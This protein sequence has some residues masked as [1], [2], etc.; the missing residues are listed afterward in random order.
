[1]VERSGRRLLIVDDEAG[2]VDLLKRYLERL[3]YEIETSVS[4]VEA[5]ARIEADPHRFDLV[6]ADLTFPGVGGKKMSGEEMLER[7][8]RHNPAL[9]ALICSGFPYVPRQPLTGFL[10]KPFLPQALAEAVE[11]TLNATEP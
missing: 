1:M 3:G 4:S 2:L 6:I 7:M 5:L 9:P 8:R 10:Q 11:R